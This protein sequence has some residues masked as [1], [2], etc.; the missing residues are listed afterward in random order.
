MICQ[1][2]SIT[3]SLETRVVWTMCARHGRRD[4]SINQSSCAG[5]FAGN[6]SWLQLELI[7]MQEW[8]P[9]VAV[10][11]DR[12]WATTVGFNRRKPPFH[13]LS[14]QHDLKPEILRNKM[15]HQTKSAWQQIMNVLFNWLMSFYGSHYGTIRTAHDLSCLLTYIIW[16]MTILWHCV[17]LAASS[18]KYVSSM[19]TCPA[20]LW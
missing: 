1:E 20:L 10:I 16:D 17:F 14:I 11:H 4:I 2:I 5:I 7:L 18:T 3:R 9:S 8:L 15:S 19:G 6:Y 13:L 12:F